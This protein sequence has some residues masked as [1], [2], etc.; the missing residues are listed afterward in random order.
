MSPKPHLAIVTLLALLTGCAADSR[1]I[2]P[3]V[4]MSQ[5]EVGKAMMAAAEP[6]PMHQWLAQDVGRWTGNSK[7]WPGAGSEPMV[8]PAEFSV[9][10]LLGGRFSETTYSADMPGMG[11]FEGLALTGYDTAAGE[12]Q[13]TWVDTFGTTMMTGSGQRLADGKSVETNF[14]FYCPVRRCKVGMRQIVTRDSNDQQT[15]RMWTADMESGQEYLMMEAVYT[16]AK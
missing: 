8:M 16:R 5:E 9:R 1:R 2:A 13:C 3:A 11:K 12:F 4:S 7:S 14:T 6:G 15:H 10:M